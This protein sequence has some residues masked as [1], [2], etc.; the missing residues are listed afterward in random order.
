MVMCAHTCGVGFGLLHHTTS[1]LVIQSDWPDADAISSTNSRKTG[2]LQGLGPNARMLSIEAEH[3]SVCGIASPIFALQTQLMIAPMR[4]ALG[5][6]ESRGQVTHS[7]WRTSR[8]SAGALLLPQQPAK[9]IS[10]GGDGTGQEGAGL[11]QG[12]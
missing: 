2:V 3:L 4:G 6:A 10:A 9:E 5:E 1:R 12:V 11:V 7:F 8:R